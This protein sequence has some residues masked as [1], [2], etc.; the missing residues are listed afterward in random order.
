MVSCS[1]QPERVLN[2]GFIGPLTGNA[3]DLGEGPAKAIELAIEEYNAA[4][5]PEAPIVKLFVEDDRW[6]GENALGLY[7]KLRR[8]HSIEVLFISHTD[9]TVALQDRVETD[10]VLLINSLNN[11]ALL[12]SLNR[13][14]FQ[15]GKKTE[16]AAQV[17]AARVLELGK[18]RVAGF[19]VTN[20]FM[21]MSAEAFNHLLAN[22]G[23]E[24]KLLAV[25]IQKD[26]YLGELAAM[27]RDGCDALVFFGYK[28]LGIAMKQAR[29][30]GMAADFFASTTTLGAGY[31]ENS[32]GEMVG[33]EFSFF[34]E[35]DGNYVLAKRFLENYEGRFGDRPFSVWPAMQAYDAAGIVLGILERSEGKRA[36]EGFADLLMR[37]MLKVNY[38]QGVCGNLAILEDGSS[39]GIY[40]SLYTVRGNGVIEKV[41]R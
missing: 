13:N 25:D 4:K 32:E 20:S 30:L 14:T 35:T 3:V 18:R 19:Y 7:K 26:D 33:T 41:R 17:V 1:P 16:E 24:A 12:A 8:E 36:N 31:F 27:K 2:V 10:G 34:T 37:E 29:E 11:D 22:Q 5:P 40:F 39:R 9:G 15:I 6:V 23:V 28:N 21:T 38:Y